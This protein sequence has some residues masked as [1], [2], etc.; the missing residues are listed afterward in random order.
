MADISNVLASDLKEIADGLEGLSCNVSPP[1]VKLQRSNGNSA[2]SHPC[3]LL[4]LGNGIEDWTEEK[5]CTKQHST[6]V[7]AYQDFINP[8]RIG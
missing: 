8:C 1:L 4:N 2:Y 7:R 3:A 6:G 5:F